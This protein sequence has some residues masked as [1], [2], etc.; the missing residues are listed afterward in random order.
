VARSDF[1]GLE[2]FTSE[3]LEDLTSEGLEDVTSEE[4]SDSSA[5]AKAAALQANRS[6]EPSSEHGTDD[7][8]L[9]LEIERFLDADAGNRDEAGWNAPAIEALPWE[10]SPVRAPWRSPE[11]VAKARAAPRRSSSPSR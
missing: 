8:Q 11:E 2:D 4:G 6:D 5:T 9:I 3:G 7:A 1:D 10:S